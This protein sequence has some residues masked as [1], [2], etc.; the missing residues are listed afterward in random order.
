M[1]LLLRGRIRRLLEMMNRFLLPWAAY[2]GLFSSTS[3][4]PCCGQPVCLVGAS[5]TGII[6]VFSAAV[7]GFF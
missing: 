2:F 1:T 4:C 6:A 3:N 5:G 7:T